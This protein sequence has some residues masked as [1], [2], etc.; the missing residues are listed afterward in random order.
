M[1][2][3][4]SCDD[5]RHQVDSIVIDILLEREGE[6]RCGLDWFGRKGVVCGDSVSGD[7]SWLHLS[8]RIVQVSGELAPDKEDERTGVA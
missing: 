7:V 3:T 6:H 5:I 2:D 4:K 1:V 8:G